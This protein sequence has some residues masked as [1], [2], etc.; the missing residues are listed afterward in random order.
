MPYSIKSVDGGFKVVNTATGKAASTRLLD[1]KTAVKQFKLLEG[2][3]HGWSP[4]GKK[5]DLDEKG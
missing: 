3:E 2:L 5:S 1:H 4:T